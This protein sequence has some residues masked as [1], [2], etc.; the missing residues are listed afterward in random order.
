MRLRRPNQRPA[1]GYDAG[2]TDDPDRASEKETARADRAMTPDSRNLA[3]APLLKIEGPEQ[4]A[5]AFAVSRETMDR[6]ELY[7]DLVLQWQKAVNLVA[8]ST[9]DQLWQ[10][11][12]GDSAQIVDILE[13]SDS[14]ASGGVWLDIGSGGGFPGLVAA[15]GE[16]GLVISFDV[17]TGAS[18]LGG[19]V[20][21]FFQ[22]SWKMSQLDFVVSI[23]DSSI[24][25]HRVIR[26]Q[27]AKRQARNSAHMDDSFHFRIL[28][29]HGLLV[30]GLVTGNMKGR[31]PGSIK[32]TRSK[33]YRKEMP[34]DREVCRT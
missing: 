24:Q 4:F 28:A 25:A 19:K 27:H 5:E 15:K 32:W 13:Q 18:E 33:Y 2:S 34:H 21:H 12:M 23:R 6:L 31:P 22:R 29:G 3:D 10:R 14:S 17:Q 26:T 16:A 8:P 7:A 9:L 20:L 1:G 11:H 30:N